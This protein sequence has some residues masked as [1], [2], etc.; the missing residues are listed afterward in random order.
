MVNM[1]DGPPHDT[2]TAGGGLS[3]CSPSH[4]TLLVCCGILAT[5]LSVTSLRHTTC[6]E[7]TALCILSQHV[8]HK[9]LASFGICPCTMRQGESL[10]YC[11]RC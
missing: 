1:S 3:L 9:P 8:P 11:L 7:L 4:A 5:W 10:C 2:N 6:L